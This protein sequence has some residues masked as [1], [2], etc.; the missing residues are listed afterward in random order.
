MERF[1]PWNNQTPSDA[2]HPNEDEGTLSSENSRQFL[3]EMEVEKITSLP[4]IPACK[5]E[6]RGSHAAAPSRGVTATCRYNLPIRIGTR[7][8]KRISTRH[9]LQPPTREL[10]L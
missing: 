2:W 9:L 7:P 4:G 10:S 6:R 1:P 3:I 5:F 8:P